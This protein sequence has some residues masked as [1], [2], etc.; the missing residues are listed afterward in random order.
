MKMCIN[1]IYFLIW[2]W[3]L[4][5]IG[6]CES[7]KWI[8]YLTLVLFHISQ[9][10]FWYLPQVQMFPRGLLRPPHLCLDHTSSAVLFPKWGTNAGKHTTWS[11][12]KCPNNNW[13]G[14]RLHCRN[15]YSH[16]ESSGLF[17]PVRSLPWWWDYRWYQSVSV[18]DVSCH[19]GCR[20]TYRRSHTSPTTPGACVA[21]N[22]NH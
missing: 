5:S 20:T 18:C 22:P 15:L 9:I 12:L 8:R 4:L 7:S 11:I 6:V 2:I 13:Y 14:I 1:L 17:L 19:T 10:M 21:A 16:E 3:Y